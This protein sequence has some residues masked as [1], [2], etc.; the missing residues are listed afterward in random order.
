V[1][2]AVAPSAAVAAA[3]AEA[4]TASGPG[5]GAAPGCEKRASETW[6]NEPMHLAAARSNNPS[7]FGTEASEA[8]PSHR[9]LAMACLLATIKLALKLPAFVRAA[10]D[11]AA[12][13]CLRTKVASPPLFHVKHFSLAS[14][15]D[16][17]GLRPAASA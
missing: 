15:R 12:A 2:D 4:L 17:N 1:I 6:M 5:H 14:Q 3:E 9:I 8:E 13:T 16:S 10:R 7:A 11:N